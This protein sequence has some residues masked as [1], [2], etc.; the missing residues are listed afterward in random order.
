MNAPGEDWIFDLTHAPDGSIWV[1]AK[2]GLLHYDGNAWDLQP[3]PD[4]PLVTAVAVTPDNTIWA[5]TTASGIMA[6]LPLVALC[7]G[8]ILFVRWTGASLTRAQT[9]KPSA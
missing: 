3:L 5:Q 7:L 8:L 9:A 4:E 1:A 2:N 6:W